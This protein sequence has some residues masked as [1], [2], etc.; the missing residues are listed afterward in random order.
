MIRAIISHNQDSSPAEENLQLEIIRL[1]W[2]ECIIF[3]FTWQQIQVLMKVA[4]L[5]P[6]TVLEHW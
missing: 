1:H 3:I 5:N 6:E 2:N 4:A